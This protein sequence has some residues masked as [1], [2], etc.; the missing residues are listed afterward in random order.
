MEKSARLRG[1]YSLRC[2]FINA[3]NY[4]AIWH[5]ELAIHF[6]PYCCEAYNNLGVIYKEQDNLEKAVMCYQSA[7]AINPKFSQSLNNLGVIY[8]VQG[9][10]SSG[11]VRTYN[12]S[13]VGQCVHIFEECHNRE[14]HVQ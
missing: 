5:Y 4:R 9:K 1:A 11:C 6:N 13:V 3:H 10:V 8:T 12:L 2:R 7:L 14:P